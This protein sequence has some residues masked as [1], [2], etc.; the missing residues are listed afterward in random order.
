MTQEENGSTV[1]DHH[2]TTAPHPVRQHPIKRLSR[3]LMGVL[4]LNLR[5]QLTPGISVFG[6][7]FFI[8]SRK[9]PPAG[10][11]A[12]ALEYVKGLPGKSVLDVGSGGGQQ[13][14][15]FQRSGRRV[16]CVD[17]GTSIYA[18]TST[19]DGLDIIYTDFNKLSPPER[20][21]LVWASHILEHQ[22]NAGAFIDKLI[23]CCADGGH[24]CITTPDPHR[25]LWG[26][27][28]SLWTPGLLAYNIV[29][30]G[31]DISTPSSSG[32]LTSS[33]SFSAQSR[34][35]YQP[36]SLTTAE[37]WAKF[38]RISLRE[39]ARTAT[40]GASVTSNNPVSRPVTVSY[41]PN[42]RSSA[43]PGQR[44]ASQDLTCT[45]PTHH[46]KK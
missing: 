7:N 19:V 45:L 11:A 5:Y 28:V 21:D 33:P 23:A 9:G 3:R 1:T 36:I 26:G 40:L 20:Y 14:K 25:N 2:Q 30:C 42:L 16:T 4:G 18:K 6:V 31:V 27:H 44:R 15:E 35:N 17:Y 12:Y 22:R 43:G 8:D 10:G 34:Y 39:L 13:A 24:V 41:R 32:G 37:I 29:L 46:P 38:L